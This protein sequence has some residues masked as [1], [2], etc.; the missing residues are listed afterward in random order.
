MTT[1]KQKQNKSS[2]NKTRAKTKANATACRV[3]RG[4]HR[5]GAAAGFAYEIT[6]MKFWAP[7]FATPTFVS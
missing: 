5:L 3:G 6:V 4:P 7:N 2:K 1:K